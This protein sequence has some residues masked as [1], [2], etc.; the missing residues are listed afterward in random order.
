MQTIYALIDPRDNAVHYVGITHDVYKRFIEHINCSKVNFPKNAW[1]IELRNA[2]KMIIMKTLQEVETREEAEEREWYWIRHFEMLNEPVKNIAKRSALARI[3]VKE[4]QA[5]AKN[6]APVLPATNDLEPQRVA[7]EKPSAE[8]AINAWHSGYS[9]VRKLAK[10]LQINEN[11]SRRIID[12]LA[13]SGHIQKNST[14]HSL[15]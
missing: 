1:V 10:A 11:Q 9:S 8:S 2:N 13:R 3:K 15:Y 7:V 14:S 6:D 5:N 4:V 12:D